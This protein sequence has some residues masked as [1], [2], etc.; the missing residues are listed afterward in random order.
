MVKKVLGL[1]LVLIVISG[2]TIFALDQLNAQ[3]D[4]EEARRREQEKE[5]YLKID[6]LAEAEIENRK[7]QKTEE[8]KVEE[9]ADTGTI[10]KEWR[11]RD[12][13][14]YKMEATK[15]E[16]GTYTGILLGYNMYDN[17]IEYNFEFED[18]TERGFLDLL[19]K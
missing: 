5:E 3:Q 13:L 8:V 2:G 10:S 6:D 4:L 7:K 1:I 19:E 15:S 18:M 16:K 14:T 17:F 11:G 9:K 12:G